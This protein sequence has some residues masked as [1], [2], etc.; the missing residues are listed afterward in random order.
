MHRLGVYADFELRDMTVSR[1]ETLIEQAWE[2][3]EAGHAAQAQRLFQEVIEIDPDNAEAWMMAGLLCAERGETDQAVLRLRRATEIDPDY[4]DPW[5]HLARL[6]LAAGQ[7]DAALADAGRAVECDDQYAEAW[8]LFAELSLRAGDSASTERAYRKLIELQPGRADVRNRLAGLLSSLGRFGEALLECREALR[9][10]PENPEIHAN[11]GNLCYQQGD[12]SGAAACFEQALRISPEFTGARLNLGNAL[13]ALGDY[14][15]ASDCY[16]RLLA[17]NPG[18]LEA[19]LSLGECHLKSGDFAQAL[20]SYQ[21]ALTIAPRM[22]LVQTNRGYA[23]AML[24]RYR[25]A[26]DAFEQGLRLE[27]RNPDAWF[28]RGLVEK[29]LG[30]FDAAAV[31]LRQASSLSPSNP[32]VKL[33][34]GLLELLRGNF[35]DGWRYYAVR[36]SVRDRAPVDPA[37]LAGDLGGKRILLVKDQGLGDEIFFLR[38]ARLLKQRGAWLACQ[39][40]AKIRSIVARL[41]FLDEVVAESDRPP[42]VDLTLSVADV[43]QVLGLV[44]IQDFPP[45]VPLTVLPQVHERIRAQLS[46]AGPGPYIGLTWWAGTRQPAKQ[47]TD[48]LAYREAP[49]RRLAELLHSAGTTPVILQRSPDADELA[50]CARLCG[51]PVVDMSGLNDDLEGML[52]LLACLDDY[53][54]VDNTNMHLSAGVGRPCR[55]L[56]PHPPEWRMLTQGTESPW[57]PDFTLYR[58]SAD[59][60]WG[61]AFAQLEKDIHAGLSHSPEAGY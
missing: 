5:L 37:A 49:M 16:R 51:H 34:L 9:M 52:A 60:D 6:R 48:R 1:A 21:A 40:D 57:F 54:G 25:E 31:S 35:R 53:V 2:Q 36:K 27:P 10:E 15:Q 38:F 59:G 39:T 24:A 32:D 61:D 55:I 42:A 33:S 3:V 47:I 19:H 23:L 44:D 26:L 20:E 43:P 22:P 13:R 17:G 12:Y 50:E 45:P 11:L 30:L 28:N 29:R 18:F 46:Q 4:P 56:V 58:Q 14:R 8:M 41:P 7:P